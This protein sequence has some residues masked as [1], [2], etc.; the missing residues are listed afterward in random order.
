MRT[1]QSVVDLSA[2]GNT[3]QLVTD[4]PKPWTW[5][6]KRAATAGAASA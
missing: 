5:V 1:G 4:E 3:R 2:R 6:R